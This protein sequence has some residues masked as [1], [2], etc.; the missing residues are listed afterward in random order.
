V[1]H[2]QGRL[3]LALVLLG[4]GLGL[5][6]PAAAQAGGEG[7]EKKKVNIAKLPVSLYDLQGKPAQLTKHLGKRYTVVNLW[8]TWC[9]PCRREMPALIKLDKKMRPR[10]VQVVGISLD[11]E[12]KGVEAFAKQMGINYPMLYG[13]P[14]YA[15]ALGVQ[16]IPI[17]LILDDAGVL[18]DGILSEVSE[19]L[20]TSKLE[21][22]LQIP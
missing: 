9:V 1:S 5:A 15:Q 3:L 11:S 21:T 22:L 14:D 12:R 17:T 6:G 7:G 16:G 10:G 2:R 19:A 13:G 4:A 18:L 8:A 20:L